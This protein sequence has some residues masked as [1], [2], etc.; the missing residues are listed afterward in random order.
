MNILKNIFKKK[1]VKITI[2]IFV[3]VL[4]A[5]ASFILIENK[6]FP[7]KVVIRNNL[8]TLNSKDNLKKLE[9]KFEYD[10]K[11]D[12]YTFIFDDNIKKELKN[13]Q[14]E[15]SIKDNLM[16]SNE[17]SRRVNLQLYTIATKI[18]PAFNFDAILKNKSNPKQIT[19]QVDSPIDEKSAVMIMVGGDIVY[20][21]P[22]F[23]V[24]SIEGPYYNFEDK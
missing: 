19:I 23:S 5:S 20:V 17:V 15:D 4:I 12:A 2:S 9:G 13:L 16:S 8:K 11:D 18:A 7:E 14:T 10:K 22:S 24:G 21:A 3:L 1:W 6:Y